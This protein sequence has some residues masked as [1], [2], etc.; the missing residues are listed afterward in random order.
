MTL[1]REAEITAPQHKAIDRELNRYLSNSF[2][3]A[4]ELNQAGPFLQHVVSTLKLHNMPVELA[5]LPVIESNYNPAA[6]SQHNAAGLWQLLPTTGRALGLTIDRYTDERRHIEK[7]TEAAL[8]Y[9]RYLHEQFDDWPLAIAAYNAGPSR[10]RAR[11][12]RFGEERPETIWDLE[13]PVETRRYVAKFFALRHLLQNAG[14]HE[15]ALR[16][17]PDQPGFERITLPTRISL[18]RVAELAE[19]DVAAIEHLNR[20]LLYRS[21]VPGG[22]H[23]IAVPSGAAATFRNN[24]TAALEQDEALFR[25]VATYVV[26]RG[27]T[28]SEIAANFRLSTAELR[29]LNKLKGNR[30]RVGQKLKVYDSTAVGTDLAEYRVREGDTLSAIA[31]RYGVA[32]AAIARQNN[33]ADSNSLRAGKI[34]VI[35]A[36]YT[37][38]KPDSQQY[39]VKAGD[40]LSE[41]AMKFSV[42]VSELRQLNPPLASGHKIV[43]GQKVSVPK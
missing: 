28:V 8:D 1:A 2:W 11:L 43:P 12:R 30:I 41:I 37:P 42:S 20:D 17:I 36:N 27:D 19:T 34:L 40:T 15:L 3:T 33:I 24:L 10:V 38:S 14:K 31:S 21:T 13:L 29:A 5:L 7:S 22:P 9:L 25:P 23:T 18:N 16:A 32:H 6:H 4:R 35:P 39:T 26:K